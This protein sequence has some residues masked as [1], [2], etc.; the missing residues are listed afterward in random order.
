MLLRLS[1]AGWKTFGRSGNRVSIV[2]TTMKLIR[3][4]T[5]DGTGKYAVIDM[6]NKKITALRRQLKKLRAMKF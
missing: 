1:S 2:Y 3:N 4:T 6:R 5:P